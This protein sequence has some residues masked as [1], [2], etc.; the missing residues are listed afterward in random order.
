MRG[1]KFRA[2]DDCTALQPYNGDLQI[3][4]DLAMCLT[5]FG[6]ACTCAVTCLIAFSQYGSSP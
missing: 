3:S 1:M 2:V 5:T 4:N 6:C